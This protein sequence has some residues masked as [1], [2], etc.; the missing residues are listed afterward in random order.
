MFGQSLRKYF[1]GQ[2][3]SAI[4]AVTGLINGWLV[5]KKNLN[6]P[7]VQSAYTYTLILIGSLFYLL[8]ERR[9]KKSKSVSKVSTLDL[10]KTHK[11]ILLGSV[12]FDVAANWLVVKAFSELKLPEVMIFSGLSTPVAI[13][14]AW[15]WN[16]PTPKYNQIQMTGVISALLSIIFYFYMTVNVN[17]EKFTNSISGVMFA[18]SSAVAYAAS[19]NFQERVAQV[20]RP[21]EFLLALGCLGSLISWIFVFVNFGEVETIFQFHFFFDYQIW[22]LITIYALILSSFYFLIPVYMSRHSA[23]SFNFSLLTANF[24][25]I[26]GSWF[27]L[28][29]EYSKWLYV[30]VILINLGLLTYYIGE[31]KG[32]K[33]LNSTTPLS[34][35]ES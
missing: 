1:F 28:Q 12:L 2:V 5:E 30:S 7:A 8:V 13:F 4:L 18:V 11:N 34:V 29:A 24:L 33:S 15:I 14:I 26:L 21:I 20:L 19:N 9:I 17:G 3:M 16:T 32:S 6:I 10:L 31:S 25:G 23:V 35:C 22:L 27:L